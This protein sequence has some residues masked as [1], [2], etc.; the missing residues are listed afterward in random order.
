[1]PKEF[2]NAGHI[3]RR[4][5]GRHGLAAVCTIQTIRFRPGKFIGLQSNNMKITR[6]FF[7]YTCE[8]IPQTFFVSGNEI[9]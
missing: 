6:T 5:R 1:M 2:G 7:F 9:I 4:I 8:K 3:L